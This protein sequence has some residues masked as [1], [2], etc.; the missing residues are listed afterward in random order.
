MNLKKGLSYTINKT[1]GTMI[2]IERG[3]FGYAG[4]IVAESVNLNVSS[5]EVVAIVGPSGC[6]KT[7]ILKTISGNLP[8]MGGMIRLD[9]CERDRIW[10]SQH[11]ARTLQNFPLFHWLTVEANLKLVCKVR[12]IPF[13]DFDGVLNEFSALHL[14]HS[15]PKTLSGGERC[16]ASLA[17]AVITKPKVLLLDEPFSGLD[18]HVKEEIAKYLFSFADL[19][20]TSVI[21]VTHDLFDACEYAKRVVVLGGSPPT[22]IRAIVEPGEKDS[23]SLIRKH[24]LTVN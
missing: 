18:L 12:K 24:M 20:G 22:T 15:Y 23:I 11:L 16:R 5:R 13:V 4:K 21:F 6:G 8:L 9:G 10:L 2:E 1:V 7:T 3:I 19:H 14:K 17:Q